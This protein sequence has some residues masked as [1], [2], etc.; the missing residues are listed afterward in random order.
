M[1][2]PRWS[3]SCDVCTKAIH[4]DRRNI[5]TRPSIMVESEDQRV[6][7]DTGPDFREQMLRDNIKWFDLV[8]LTHSHNDHIASMIELIQTEATIAAPREVLDS[9]E[10]KRNIFSYL[11]GRGRTADIRAI[12]SMTLG[13]LR[14]ETI[15][16]THEKDISV[17]NTPT[18]GYLFI[19]GGKRVAYIPD[20]ENIID[21]EKVK[22]C[23]LFISDG[24]TIRTKWGHAGVEGSIRNY[25]RY[26]PKRMLITHLNHQKTHEE[27][28]EEFS[29]HGNI[30][31]AYDGMVIEL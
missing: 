13:S 4:S 3:C 5:R 19:E 21:E 1:G 26:Y 15:K 8:L 28:A 27:Y 24:A 25:S 14:I 6:I 16:V 10:K 23:D 31:P 2:V 20:Y 7:V 29:E 22:G 30:Q 12:N 11:N 9:I 17:F 18:V